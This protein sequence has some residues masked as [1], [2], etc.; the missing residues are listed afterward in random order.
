ML[1]CPFGANS[2]QANFKQRIVT[3]IEEATTFWPAESYH[4][5]CVVPKLCSLKPYTLHSKALHPTPY[6][7]HPTLCT[8]HLHHTPY[9]QQ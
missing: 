1:L 6:T 5:Q 8:I 4:Q 2:T 3:E 7:L 9:H